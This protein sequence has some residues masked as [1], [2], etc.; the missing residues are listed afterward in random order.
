MNAFIGNHIYFIV[1]WGQWL[2]VAISLLCLYLI[3]RLG[4]GHRGHLPRGLFGWLGGVFLLLVT[5]VSA[6]VFARITVIKPNVLPILARLESLK[7]QAAPRLDY[8]LVASDETEAITDL[9]GRVVLVNF[10]ATWCLPCR[11]EMPDL[12]RLQRS[13]PSDDLVVLTLSDESRDR[14]LAHDSEM[15]YTMRS[16][17]LESFPWV[18]MGSERPV[19]FL[20]DRQGVVREY[21]TGPWD[22]DHFSEKLEPYL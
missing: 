1:H 2:M 22:Y 9:E 4:R 19:T 8:R 21:F 16:G 20:V 15:Q 17:Y 14:L 13:H 7:G 12:D 5:V 10:W 18:D 11:H 6:L 3:Y